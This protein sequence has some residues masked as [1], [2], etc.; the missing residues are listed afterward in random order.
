MKKSKI[1]TISAVVVLIVGLTA[2]SIFATGGYFRHGYGIK[3]GAL[4]GAGTAL[5]L[6]TFGAASN[7]AGLAFIGTRY[8]VNFAYFSPSRQFTVTGNPSGFPGTFG[9]APGVTESESN[10]FPMP[11]LGANWMLNDKM[12]IGAALFGN[13]GMNTDYPKPIFG[14]PNS[15]DA[16]VNLEQMFFGL[17]YSIKLSETQAIGITGLFA[18]QRFAAK[19]LGMFGAMGMSSDPANLSGNKHSI[20]TGVG[21]RVGYQGRL[22][23]NLALGAS[24]QLKTSMSE[25]DE[26][27][28]LFAEHGKFDIPS[29]WNVGLAFDAT[30]NFTIAVDI[31]QILYSGVK[32]I[33]NPIDPMALPPAFPDGQGGFVPNP[34]QVPLGAD[35]G[36]GFGWDDI[37]IY[38]LGLLYKVQDWTLMAG[39]SYGDNPV[40]ESEVLF[41]IL[42]PAVIQQ[43]I[44]FGVTKKIN[45]SNEISVAFMYAPS[46]SVTGA[47]IFEAPNQQTI[48]IEMSQFQVEVG[49]A[50]S[51]K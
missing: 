49:Y 46:N 28:G 21:F 31:Q 26:Y 45:N 3:Y 2:Q 18:W 11:S 47:N 41:N 24:Y 17:T 15:P 51:S 33:A 6:S 29:T 8:D 7:P 16:G 20:S 5:S 44:T 37:L 34:K 25:F 30:K 36:S 19:G 35:N 43:H 9:L 27:K 13:G 23:P 32:S 10:G 48:K 50:F 39:Y 12:A 22:L 4:A 14:D 42:A 38:K 1:L 40:K